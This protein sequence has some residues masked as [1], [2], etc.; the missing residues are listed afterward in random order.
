MNQLKC[1]GKNK[2]NKKNE[3]KS[4]QMIVALLGI[5]EQILLCFVDLYLFI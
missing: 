5:L 2:I 1:S 3:I 4:L